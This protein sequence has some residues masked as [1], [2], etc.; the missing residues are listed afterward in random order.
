MSIDWTSPAIQ[1]AFIAAIIG[2]FGIVLAAIVGVLGAIIGARTAADAA[3][4]AAKAAQDVA[5]ADREE[6]RHADA[7]RWQREDAVRRRTRSEA[8]ARE[9]IEHVAKVC[10]LMGWNAG[11]ARS[12]GR[13][14][15]ATESPPDDYAGAP[16]EDISAL[17]R[18]VRRAA[19]EIDDERVRE[20]LHK[21]S[22]LLPNA[23]AAGSFGAAHPA[24]VAWAAQQ[25]SETLISAYLR[26][27]PLPDA[28]SESLADQFEVFNTAYGAMFEL[29]ADYES[30][31]A[32]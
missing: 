15:V 28:L 5:S 7:L 17:C 3:R 31:D 14:G 19:L 23:A 2:L 32:Q 6:A 25:T 24:R 20:H 29:W 9:A 1:G 12:A 16:I 18:P 11:R 26:G 8:V 4:D 30:M 21:V 13:S 27:E 10:E 22:D